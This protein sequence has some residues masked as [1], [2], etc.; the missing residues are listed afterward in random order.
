MIS[1]IINLF[2][3]KLNSILDNKKIVIPERGDKLVE[4]MKQDISGLV[5]YSLLKNPEKKTYV[6]LLADIHD[7]VD[8]CKLGEDGKSSVFIDEIL[9]SFLKEDG[10]NVLLEEVP[11]TFNLELKELWPDATHTQRLKDWYIDNQDKVIPVDIR[12]FLVPFSFQKANYKMI[13]EKELKMRMSKYVEVLDSLFFLNEISLEES[14]PFFKNI[15]L[16][17][18]NKKDLNKG[19]M[20][21]YKELKGFYKELRSKI[22]LEETFGEIY[23]KNI[24]WF[25]DLEGLKIAIMDWYTIL[26]LLS[27]KNSV[28]HFGLAHYDHVKSILIKNF[29]FTIIKENGIQEIKYLDTKTRYKACMKF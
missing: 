15:L 17:L 5:G 10:Y 22:N 1:E 24:E 23:E 2:L 12:P 29:G 18:E 16:A 13:E 25:R 6:L 7:G 26:M 14:I 28:I 21:L 3:E 27:N 11:R 19:I 9:N 20:R 8:Y 4:L